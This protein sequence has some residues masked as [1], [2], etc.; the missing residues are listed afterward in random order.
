FQ[1]AYNIFVVTN[2]AHTV[3]ETA[4][5]NASAPVSSTVSLQLAGPSGTRVAPIADLQVTQVTAP[6]T[7]L[8]GR[9]LTVSWTVT[10][11]GQGSTNAD[12]WSDDLWLSTNAAIGTGGTDIYLGTAQHNNRLAAGGNYTAAATFTLA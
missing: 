10:N 1:G 5:N 12:Y 3:Y 8:A 7:A 2:D 11:I 4:T 6:T 9:A